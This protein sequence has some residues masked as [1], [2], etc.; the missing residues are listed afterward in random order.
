M[1]IP[2]IGPGTNEAKQIENTFQ[3]GKLHNRTV[4]FPVSNE[5]PSE[6]NIKTCYESCQENF[7]FDLNQ[8]EENGISKEVQTH[9]SFSQ[10]QTA[11]LIDSFLG[12][13]NTDHCTIPFTLNQSVRS[14]ANELAFVNKSEFIIESEENLFED[15]ENTENFSDNNYEKNQQ[16]IN[17]VREGRI[18]EKQGHVIEEGKT[19]DREINV[20]KEVRVNENKELNLIAFGQAIINFHKKR[21]VALATQRFCHARVKKSKR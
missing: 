5:F 10:E 6:L 8:Y 4:T 17:S 1:S 18:E 3:Q 13:P 21:W 2:P 20:V 16:G 12:F 14:N 9:L 11:D 7:C 15:S 19:I